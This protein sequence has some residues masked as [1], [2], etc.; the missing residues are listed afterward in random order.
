[1]KYKKNYIT[2]LSILPNE[3]QNKILDLVFIEHKSFL[4]CHYTKWKLS[5][6]LFDSHED[7][8]IKYFNNKISGYL[9]FNLKLFKTLEEK[10]KI[11]YTFNDNLNETLY[12]DSI[13]IFNYI[14]DERDP[15][16]DLFELKLF[17]HN[18]KKKVRNIKL[19]DA[20]ILLINAVNHDIQMYSEYWAIPNYEF[21]KI[22][23]NLNKIYIKNIDNKLILDFEID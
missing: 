2:K 12:I 23:G 7:R 18:Y 22:L 19:E 17:N 10:N 3:I 20:L 13:K 1:M 15:S 14:L 6:E 21:Y 9:P 4:C 11:I 8:I 5:E 16:V